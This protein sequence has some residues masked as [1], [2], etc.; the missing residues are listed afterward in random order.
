MLTKLDGTARG[1][2]IFAIAQKLAKPIRFVGV[3]EAAED[4]QDFRAGAFVDA[5]LSDLA[6][7]DD[8]AS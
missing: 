8:D 1:G 3:G 5:L 4:L 2:V 7:G 6:D